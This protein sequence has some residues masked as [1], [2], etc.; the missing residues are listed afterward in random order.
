MATEPPNSSWHPAF[1]PNINAAAPTEAAF[2]ATQAT[3]S[4][5]E[6]PAQ[7]K[8]TTT[9]EPESQHSIQPPSGVESSNA[10]FSQ[11]G[12]DAGD[13]WPASE[14]PGSQEPVAEQSPEAPLET[15]EPE[16][17]IP[18][19]P[20]AVVS[21][22]SSSMSFA[23]T[24]SHDLDLND[25]D[26]GDWNLSRTDTDL[27]KFMPP[28]DRTNSFPVVPMMAS[29]EFDQPLPATQAL[30]VLEEAERDVDVADE[31]YLSGTAQRDTSQLHHEQQTRNRASSQS[32]GGEMQ[33]FEEE[34]SDT[35]YEEGLPLISHAGEDQGTPGSGGSSG[36]SPFDDEPGN[37]ED[38]FSHVQDSGAD[39][40]VNGGAI[41]PLERKSTMQ[42]MNSANQGTLSRQSTLEETPEEEEELAQEENKP[43]AA[44]PT[45]DLA[46]KWE[47]AF[48]DDDDGEF[49]LE[50]SNTENKEVDPAAF[51]GSDDEGF[52][53]DEEPVPAPAPAPAPAPSSKQPSASNP[54]LPQAAAPQT[55]QSAYASSPRIAPV[56][57]TSTPMYNALAPT[58][59]FGAVPQ[60]G[61]PPQPKP[62]MPRAQSY[63]DKSKGGYHSPYDL[64]SDLVTTTVKP[65]KR[66]SMQQLPRSTPPPSQGPV[67]PPRSAS[68]YAP[69]PP[70]ASSLSPPT[71]SHG[72]PHPPM[73]QKP[74]T[75]AAS[76]KD[77]FFEE[78]PMV[79][80]PRPSS[81]HSQRAASPA[82]HAPPMSHAPSMGY[83]PHVPSPLIPPAALHSVPPPNATQM[84]PPL[85]PASAPPPS[86]QPAGIANLVAPERASPY[87][88]LS[89][90]AHHMPPPATNTARY[91][92]APAHG[93]NHMIPP[94][95]P[96]AR[97]SPAP[98][99]TKAH[100]PYGPAGASGIPP[101]VLPHQPRTSSPLTHCESSRGE[102]SLAERRANSSFEPRLNRV[103]SLPPTREV[104]EEEDV[105]SPVRSLSATH[106]PP[107]AD[108]RYNPV[109]PPKISRNT[110]P[111]PMYAGQMTLSPPKRIPSYVPQALP[112]AQ[113][114][115]IPPPRAQTQSP[116]ATFG[117]RAAAKSSDSTR[118]PSSAHSH[119][120]PIMTKP[121][122]S[123]Y[124]P[125]HRARGP[126]LTMNLVLPT[127][128]RENDPL[129]RWR[130]VPIFTWGVGGT[131]VTSFPHSV[132]RYGINQT[133][134]TIV[135]T[136]GEVKVRNVKDIEPLQERL[137][138]FPGPLRGK[139]KKKETVAWLTAGIETLEKD[140]PEVQF[141]AHLS[142]EAKRAIERLLLWKILRVFV[143]HDGTLE[144]TPAA[145]KAVREILA[146]G[147]ITPTADNDALFS[148]GAGIGVESISVTPM[149]ADGA[150][151]AT[152][153]QVRHHLLRGDREKAVWVC[154]DKRLW[155]H[156]ML[157]SNTASP[158][159]YKQVVQEFVRK[160]VNYPGHANESIGALYKILSGSHEDCVDELVPSHARAGLQLM[161]TA[162]GSG[163][164]RDVLDGLDKWRET[165]SLVLSN[166]SMDDMRGL[167]ALGNLLSSY[168][169]AEAAHVCFLFARNVSVFGGL[170]D[171]N[172]SFVLL[173]SD[174][175][176]QLDQFA[177]ET[178]PLQL[179]EVYEYGLSLAGGVAASAG[180]PH[181]AAYKLQH[182]MTLAEYG[183]RD[184]ALQYCDAIVQSMTSQTKR[185]PYF[186]LAL[187]T[188]LDDFMTRLKQAPKEEGNSWISKPSMNKVSDSM[189]N[190]FNKFVAGEE[191]ENGTGAGADGEAGPFGRIATTP[192]ISRSPSSS[193]F[194]VY[195]GQSPAYPPNAP[196]PPTTGVTARY[197][198]SSMT[199]AASAN[200]YEPA[201]QFTSAPRSSMERTSGEHAP[202]SYEPSYPGANSAPAPRSSGE[203]A[204]NAYEPAYPGVN[205]AS[206][207]NGSYA[208]A[209]HTAPEPSVHQR[210]AL[211]GA[212]VLSPPAQITPGYQPYGFPASASMPVLP[213]GGNNMQSETPNQGYQQQNFGYEPPQMTSN[214]VEP[215]SHETPAE[216]TSGGYEPPS[217]GYEPPSYN[218]DE[219]EDKSPRK[220]KSFMDDYD[221]DV[222]AMNQ[223]EKSKAEKDRENSE[224][225]RKAAEEDAK[226]AAAAASQKK[227]WGF[228]GWFGGSKKAESP[229]PGEQSPGKAIKAKLGEASSFVYDPDLKRWVN[230][231]PG[232]ENTPAKT[233][234]PPPPRSGPR[235]VS[236]TPPPPSATPPP[237][238]PLTSSN[239]APPPL[240]LPKMRSATPELSK[241]PS[242]ESL[243]PPLMRRSASNTSAAS[244]P[245]SRPTTS[246]SNASSIDDLLGAAAPRKPGQ[247]KARKS[248]RYVDV[249]AK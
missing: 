10:W 18:P 131:M 166:R 225:F 112:S 218:P 248:G 139:S 20:K 247:K 26:D 136:P 69:G 89:T 165:L 51:F 92:P 60:Y 199:P 140:I 200:P 232:A 110:P 17:T 41:P 117:H 73:G 63:A 61:A 126:S 127:D 85:A 47:D 238:P 201:S 133:A 120:S 100:G 118:R 103:S 52:L 29:P 119:H 31:E 203:Y 191:N 5:V 78:L 49:L 19:K 58:T 67:P 206:V 12:D 145:E 102:V 162:A 236:G 124:A 210:S 246:M 215:E 45:E 169:R 176:Q 222:P 42:V 137:A 149:Q 217:Y 125:T 38:F 184:K 55:A 187:E 129:Q 76:H 22:H 141:H 59:P 138:K 233:A 84:V 221:D 68:M 86:Q 34:S 168:G 48:A 75:P 195:G 244:G 79:P 189:W 183:Y 243:A 185:S 163:P 159:L 148:G 44:V 40:G 122:Q 64:P 186:N 223:K 16:S 245:P 93:A 142:L 37:D 70:S 32:M 83:A 157:I 196:Q 114:G 204:R 56:Q 80:K 111:P 24:V 97:Y 239:S 65:R 147:T 62:E 96:S 130:G 13:S 109:S 35:R 43:E 150:D 135:R 74:P 90:P 230:K 71:S 177:K 14:E 194:E 192:T 161:S 164:T 216:T 151:S 182:A 99:A 95:A 30:D 116:T 91:S 81:R 3:S 235:S 231:K 174:H 143:E 21:Q 152:M 220:K 36:A 212:P 66:A 101:P 128:G 226:R 107:P 98:P 7:P 240:M 211:A 249:M 188:A 88:A 175:H 23:R 228:S 2:D 53:E 202:N 82:Q 181:L 178:E 213:T 105:I 214:H 6:P 207:P 39:S 123:T 28:S 146:P 9:Q 193:N 57:A 134:P 113:P 46:A 219:D 115:F 172:A 104:E 8:E 1:M 154:V 229:A 237:P 33:A 50:D 171:P 158:D 208:P 241:A 160:E 77:S 54:Y 156:A 106:V 72:V 190:R 205:S 144:G 25:D 173:G 11:D 180:T 198:P 179:S 4:T 132:P 15:T 87:A 209:S 234:T 224:M 27:F 153:D 227:G 121:S 167:N 94:A 242:M 170:D 108:S 155:G 197:A